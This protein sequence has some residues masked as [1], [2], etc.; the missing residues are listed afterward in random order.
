MKF[1][2]DLQ[3]RILIG[4]VLGWFVGFLSADSATGP[5]LWCVF[6]AIVIAA[7]DWLYRDDAGKPDH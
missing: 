6:G 5:L 1:G 3:E 4:A 2:E 7:F